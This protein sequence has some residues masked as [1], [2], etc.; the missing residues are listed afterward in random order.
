M[1]IKDVAKELGVSESTVSRAISGKGRIGETTRNRVLEFIKS[2]NYIPGAG[3]NELVLSNTRNIGWVMPDDC[4][5]VE[6][7]FFQRCMMGLLES[8]ETFGYHLLITTSGHNDISHIQDLINHKKVDG[9]VLARTNVDDLA[10]PFLK[11]E[12]TPFIAIGSYSDAQTIQI[13]HAHR[14][15]CKE[16]TA[17]Q[18]HKGAER[19]GLIGGSKRYIVNLNRYQ[20][21]ID[22]ILE[23]ERIPDHNLIYMDVDNYVAAEIAV[24][25]LIKKKADCILCTDDAICIHVLNKLSKENVRVPQDIKIGSF[26]NSSLLENNHPAI[27]CIDFNAHELGNY[28]GKILIDCMEG[29]DYSTGT[30]LGYE[31]CTKEST[32]NYKNL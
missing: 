7:P 24:E 23:A 30:L 12:R 27:S 14:A 4:D 21:Y 20:G 1:T 28:A 11:E 6:I 13:D 19:V 18:L 9:V 3:R 25:E 2:H 26:Y 15:A 32:K 5:I 16:F 31:I 17:M 10:I 8:T 22:A 29:R